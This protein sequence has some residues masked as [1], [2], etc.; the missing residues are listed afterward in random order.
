MQKSE[1][2][3]SKAAEWWHTLGKHVVNEGC[4]WEANHENSSGNLRRVNNNLLCT[5]LGEIIL[6][7]VWRQSLNN[8]WGRISGCDFLWRGLVDKC[9]GQTKGRGESFHQNAG[10]TDV[11]I[12]SG[13]LDH[14]IGWK[15][16]FGDLLLWG[17]GLGC[18]RMHQTLKHFLRC[19]GTL[20]ESF[21]WYSGN[22][23]KGTCVGGRILTLGLG[24]NKLPVSTQHVRKILVFRV[25]RH[26][27]INECDF[28]V[29]ERLEK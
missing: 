9:A 6:K 3:E 8:I 25:T 1:Q 12:F 19:L 18:C 5:T 4:T 24:L 29:K 11:W 7:H 14:E 2:S 23:G 28:F 17:S 26:F 10:E 22:D 13:V 20:E 27:E 15:Q 21:C 16:C